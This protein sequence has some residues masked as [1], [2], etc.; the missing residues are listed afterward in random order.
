MQQL[1]GEFKDCYY[2]TREGKIYNSETKEEIEADQ[3]HSFRLKTNENVTKKV[4]LR[5][6]YRKVFG[7]NFC[8]DNIEDLENETWKPIERT[9]N[10]YW[11]SNK[12]RVKSLVNY[13]AKILK[14]SLLKGYERVDIYQEGQRI[15]KLVSRLVAAAFLP[16]PQSMDMQ[17]H[18]ID[19]S[20]ANNNVENL[21]WLTPKQHKAAHKKLN[22]A[23]EKNNA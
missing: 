3:S 13:E 6:L 17:L 21:V 12:G 9:D 22:Q 11:I 18:H 4:A 1:C 20:R 8:Q 14:P 19:G 15:S 23:K 2:L 10:K 16:I 5:V 7:E